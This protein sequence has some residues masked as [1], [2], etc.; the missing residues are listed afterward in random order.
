[1]DRAM[2]AVKQYYD[3]N[4]E[5]EW[6]RLDRHPFEF[7]FTTYMMD[8]HIR[9]GDRIL[10]I[11][12]G[13]GRYSIHYAKM[14]CEVTLV[15]LSEG[16]IAYAGKKA[17]EAGVRLSMHVKNCLELDA[18]D[19]GEFDHVF[20]MGPLYHLQKSAERTEAVR[21]ALKRLRTGGCFYCSFILDFAG[22]IYDLKNGPGHLPVDLGNPD[23]ARLLDSLVSETEY[24]GA[25][26]APA[27]FTNQK[28][29]EPFMR[30][31]PLDKLHLF[32]QEGILAPNEKQVLSFPQEEI[33]LWIKTAKL[34][35]EKPEYLSYSEHAMYIGR[36]REA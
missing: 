10:D 9:K 2:Q 26:F 7:V 22:F 24:V 28:G 21:L 18:L 14:G 20:L 32:G 34:L 33:D 25:A 15:D 30:Q 3:E 5:M 16:N 19:L 36:K 17:Q 1:M 8:K 4:A 27:C 6:E 13:P 35:L 29:I 11:G 23:T 31:F 12:G